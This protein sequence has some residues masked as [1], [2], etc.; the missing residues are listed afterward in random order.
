M[1]SSQHPLQFG[2]LREDLSQKSHLLGQGT[3]TA[4][5]AWLLARDL[6]LVVTPE[7]LALLRLVLGK[8]FGQGLLDAR[9]GL[10]RATA[11]EP[12]M[13]QDL[14]IRIV[15]DRVSE[16]VQNVHVLRRRYPRK[17]GGTVL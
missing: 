4:R 9:Q 15:L 3:E 5:P 17:P 1:L 16:R 11:G 13:L 10:S 7:A 8:G 12:L 2:S 14:L 6:C